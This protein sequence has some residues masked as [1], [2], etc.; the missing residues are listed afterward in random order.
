[1]N[2][3]AQKNSPWRAGPPSE[4]VR[5]P[6]ALGEGSICIILVKHDFVKS[7]SEAKGELPCSASVNMRAGT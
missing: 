6:G 1:M 7:A 4:G 5:P 3:S 2:F